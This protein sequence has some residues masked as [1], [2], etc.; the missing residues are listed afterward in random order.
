MAAY[1]YIAFLIGFV[2]FF[3]GHKRERWIHVSIGFLLV[4]MVLVGE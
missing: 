4:G 2:I 1:G 3:F